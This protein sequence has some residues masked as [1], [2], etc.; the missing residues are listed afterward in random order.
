MRIRE[1]NDCVEKKCRK[2]LSHQVP[3]LDYES[4]LESETRRVRNG[5]SAIFLTCP[6][7]I[8]KKK[9]RQLIY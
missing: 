5:S 8:E 4:P 2:I 9:K 3:D 7:N 1:G 6:Y